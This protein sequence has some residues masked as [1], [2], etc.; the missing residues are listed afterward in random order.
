M[1]ASVI[2]VGSNMTD[3]IAYVK[4]APGPGETIIGDRFAQG[5]GGKGA[6]QAVMASSLG[7]KVA[8]V[9][10]LG[11]DANGTAYR[12]HFEALGIDTSHTH[13]APGSSGCAPIWVEADGQ[14][15]IIVIPGANNS[16]TAAQAVAAVD[17]LVAPASVVV[18]QFEIPQ[19][20][21][22]AAFAAAK[23]RGA[24]TVLN[25]APAESI[26]PEL[27][28]S[29]D[30]LIPNESEFALL[31]TGAPTDSPPTDAA[32]LAFAAKVGARLLVTLGAAGVALVDK[33]GASVQRLA[34]P[35]TTGVVDTTGAGDAFVGAFCHGLASGLNEPDAVELGMACAS[36][37]VT[38]EGT[39]TSF[40]TLARCRE[41]GVLPQK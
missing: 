22:A 6:N 26:L 24:I 35:K 33:D 11:D 18:G 36:D 10:C 31:A 5:F 9:T 40:P 13:T 38:R 19:A 7:A 3:M 1:A 28:A 4:R 25:P 41:L 2:C 15:R 21:T 8:M 17:A 14:N 34:A 20:V 30:W 23:K 16:L 27:L 12:Q 37:S 29:S 39:Q 32:I